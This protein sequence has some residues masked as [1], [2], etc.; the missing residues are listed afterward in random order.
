MVSE[1]YFLLF[2]TADA[3]KRAWRNLDAKRRA[4]L[5]PILELTRGRKLKGAGNDKAGKPL[6]AEQLLQTPGVYSFEKNWQSSVELM[7]GCERFFLD[8][9]REPS[10]SCAEI[11]ELGASTHGYR[12]WTDFVVSCKRE[13]SKVCPTLLV[14]PAASD[15]EASYVAGLK[16]QFAVFRTEFREIAYRV[17]VVEDEQFLFDLIALKS[18]I[19]SFRLIGGR[20]FVVLDHEF[21]R[22]GN[23]LVHAKRTTQIIHSIYQQVGD[24]DVIVLATSFPK[25]VTEVGDEGHDRFRVEEMFLFDEVK[26]THRK[27]KYG[28]YGS[29][30]PT[31]NDEIVIANGWRPRIDFVSRHNGLS[32]YYFRERRKVVG[33][34]SVIFQGEE[35]TKNILAPY[36]IHY[37]SVARSVIGF[38]P[39]Y[40]NLGSSWGH[41][42]ILCAAAGKVPSNSPSYWISVRM[43]IHIVQILKYF[44]IDPV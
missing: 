16:A 33:T 29:I 25:S 38:A 5:T 1:E 2:K 37:S 23:G 27:V 26:K 17:S 18:E 20:F 13:G 9:T 34:E 31:R 28:D 24:V 35:K 6:S 36:S 4:A 39:Y 3:E 41:G 8:L 10:L 40:E 7:K 12:R 11:E 14:N 42:E 19:A 32:T 30:N 44:Q 21:V 22:P 15:D 43:E